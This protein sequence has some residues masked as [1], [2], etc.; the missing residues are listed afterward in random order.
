MITINVRTAIIGKDSPKDFNRSPFTLH[1]SLSTIL[2]RFL[3]KY[4]TIFET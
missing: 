1:K 2:A 4:Y 3:K